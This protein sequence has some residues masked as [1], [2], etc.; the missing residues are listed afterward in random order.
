MLEKAFQE[1]TCP[2]KGGQQVLA[3]SLVPS[4]VSYCLSEG[5]R[6]Y[7]VGGSYSEHSPLSLIC[8]C[9]LHIS[10]TPTSLVIFV[11]DEF[12]ELNDTCL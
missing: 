9:F 4:L 2:E 1:T 7:I 6:D 5:K 10:H 12:F 8:I 3:K 11:G